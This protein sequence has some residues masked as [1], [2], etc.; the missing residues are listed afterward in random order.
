MKKASS[1]IIFVIWCIMALYPIMPAGFIAFDK[2]VSESRVLVQYEIYGCGSIVVRVLDG[3][4]EITA[5]L[6][7]KCPEIATDELV[8]T[9]D[10]NEPQKHF[11]AAEFRTG[12]LAERYTYIVDGEVVGIT[13]GARDCCDVT[14]YAY[15]EFAPHFKAERWYFTEYVPNIKAWDRFGIIIWDIIL[16]PFI[17]LLNVIWNGVNLYYFVVNKV[18]RDR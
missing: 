9:N 1:I 5:E 3:G 4:E 13:D 2:S 12:G 14:K 17:T 11:D 8:F 6:K 7:E 15:N 18:R 10:S 16:L